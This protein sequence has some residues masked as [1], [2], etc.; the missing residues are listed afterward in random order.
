MVNN[1]I[2]DSTYEVIEEGL[3]K[4][5]DLINLVLILE[6]GEIEDIVIGSKIVDLVNLTRLVLNFEN[7]SIGSI[8]NA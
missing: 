7:N 8:G 3:S 5:V 2:S 6:N 1:S 4:F